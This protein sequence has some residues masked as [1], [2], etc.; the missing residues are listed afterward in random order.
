LCDELVVDTIYLAIPSLSDLV[1]DDI[2]CP[3]FL[4]NPLLSN[5]EHQS[6]EFHSTFSILDHSL[7]LSMTSTPSMAYK[8]LLVVP[9]SLPNWVLGFTT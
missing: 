2:P 1:I 4:L 3:E 5:S 8:V 7:D 6:L 9:S